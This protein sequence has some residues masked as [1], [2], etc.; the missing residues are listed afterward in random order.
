MI[1]QHNTTRCRTH[2]QTRQTRTLSLL[3]SARARRI[4]GILIALLAISL[5]SVP[6]LKARA[7]ME[8][9]AAGQQTNTLHDKS[10]VRLAMS[11]SPFGIHAV[12]PYSKGKARIYK[13][14]KP[15]KHKGPKP[16]GLGGKIPDGYWGAFYGAYDDP[17][18]DDVYEE[19]YQRYGHYRTM[20]VRLKDGYYWP[21]NFA[22]NGRKLGK[23]R[24]RCQE[25]CTDPVRLYYMPSTSDKIE[26]M[27][28]LKGRR[29]KDLDTAFLYRTVLVKGAKCKPEPWSE[30]A[31]AKHTAYAKKDAGNKRRQ[32]VASTRRLEKRRIAIM[33]KRKRK[34]A[35]Y[36][37]RRYAVAKPPYRRQKNVRQN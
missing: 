13:A 34:I 36:N 18:E 10:L 14:A 23:D 37:K 5:L 33:K 9:A 7:N 25:S 11:D 28:D 6:A 26:D 21:I 4:G 31:K 24:I 29:Y 32:H 12:N 19:G 30:A 1:P 20:C 2:R 15:K 35:N 3:R 8:G 16:Q 27:R 17:Y 22:Q